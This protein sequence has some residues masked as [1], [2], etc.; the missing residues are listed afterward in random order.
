MNWTPS[1]H[2]EI[3]PLLEMFTFFLSQ[4]I[5]GIGSD[6]K[7]KAEKREIH[8]FVDLKYAQSS[9]FQ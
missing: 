4:I 5:L 6:D 7:S 8:V 9:N 3:L 1:S 2:S